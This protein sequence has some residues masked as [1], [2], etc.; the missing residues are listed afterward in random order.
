MIRFP[1][2][3]TGS[4]P[5]RSWQERMLGPSGSLCLSQIEAQ[6]IRDEKRRSFSMS[7]LNRYAFTVAAGV[8]MASSAS[9]AEPCMSDTSDKETAVGK[10]SI[11]RAQDAA[12]RP[13]R[14]YILTLQTL[15]CL[16]AD[17]PEDNVKKTST[18]Q[19]FSTQD[20]VSNQIARFVGKSI[21]V[22]GRPFPAHTADRHG[23]Q[24]NRTALITVQSWCNGI[25]PPLA[26]SKA[27]RLET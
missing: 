16:T 21:S 1:I 22:R 12:G 17:D 2:K 13:E 26:G 14:P 3:A 25:R 27:Y 23:Y 7:V 19:I 20:T 11:G 24:R 6:P 4:A 8:F 5:R 9:A 10:L 15:A 18:I